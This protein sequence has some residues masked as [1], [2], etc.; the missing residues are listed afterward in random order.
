MEGEEVERREVRNRSGDRLDIVHQDCPVET[1][2]MRDPRSVDFPWEV[3]D[4][5]VRSENGSRD[6][7]GGLGA[8]TARL[9]QE[10][11]DD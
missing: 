6:G 7:E 1:E 11:L 9:T 4:A 8:G 3:G 2:S 10:G 5:G